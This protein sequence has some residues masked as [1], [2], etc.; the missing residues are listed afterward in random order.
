MAIVKVW[1]DN[2]HPHTEE[3]KGTKITIPAG[4]SIE[5]EWEEAIEFKGA[6]TSIKRDGSGNAL[7]ESYK[8]IRVERPAQLPFRDEKQVFHATGQT[9]QTPAEMVA[10]AKAYAAQNP[11]RV[12][13]GTSSDTVSVKKEELD[14]LL[15]RVAALESQAP[16][17]RGPGRPKKEA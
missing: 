16:E 13:E 12:V 9:F 2:K 3:F 7:P 1:N 15:A 6:F 4:G 11:D 8:M 10:F 5:M 17:K 14:A